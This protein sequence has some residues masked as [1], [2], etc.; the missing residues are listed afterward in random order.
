VIAALFGKARRAPKLSLPEVSVTA[1]NGTVL[2][3]QGFEAGFDPVN[4]PPS[5]WV[6]LLSE[7]VPDDEIAILGPFS[8]RKRLRERLSPEIPEPATWDFFL[9]GENRDNPLPYARRAIGFRPPQSEAEIR[10]PYWMWYVQWPGYEREPA[11]TRFGERLSITHL[12]TSLKDRFGPLP[13]H[14]AKAEAEGLAPCVIVSSHMK[15]HRLRLYMQCKS[16]MGCDAYGR[17]FT[18]FDGPKRDLLSKYR[19]NLCPENRIGAGYIT[20]KIPEAY[21]SGCVPITYCHPDDLK[22]DFNPDAV[23]NLYG[24]SNRQV[25]ARLRELAH[26]VD[27][28]EAVRSQPLLQK[29]I[30]L[31]DLIAFLRVSGRDT[32]DA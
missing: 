4:G 6:D 26:D 28:V 5:F 18:R 21:L 7:H 14:D 15:R 11:Y 9:S 20:E 27:A 25:R 17:H 23:V 16:V 10:F 3:F 13:A 22:R 8:L 1:A 32:A 24:L 2:R 12:K 19:F 29:D 31:D 30:S